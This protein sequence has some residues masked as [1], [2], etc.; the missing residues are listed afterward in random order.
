M[1]EMSVI[2]S[3]W[4]IIEEEMKKKH[5]KKLL[6]VDIEVGDYLDIVDESL[7][8]CFEAVTMESDVAKDAELNII[9]KKTVV[10]CNRCK[11]TWDFKE[12]W[13]ICE[14]CNISDSVIIAGK[15]FRILSLEIEE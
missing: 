2:M 8:L 1:H 10:Q 13:Y 15:D 3:A 6:S 5:Y 11:S 12:N 9:H 14:K 4:N 7:E